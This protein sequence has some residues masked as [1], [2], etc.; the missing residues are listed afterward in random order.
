M[1]NTGSVHGTIGKALQRIEGDIATSK[2]AANSRCVCH[3]HYSVYYNKIHNDGTHTSSWLLEAYPI[4]NRDISLDL[5]E[6]HRT[7]HG[8]KQDA[9]SVT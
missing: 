1:K 6:K 3:E 7:K 2:I 4:E 8:E 5:T 9:S